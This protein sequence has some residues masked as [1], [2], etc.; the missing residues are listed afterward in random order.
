MAKKDV[1]GTMQVLTA[2]GALIALLEAIG[3]FANFKFEISIGGVGHGLGYGIIDAILLLIMAIITLLSAL[4]PNDTVSFNAGVL[5]IFGILII[6]F[7]S[8]LGG[9]LVIIAGIVG[10]LS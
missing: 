2:I 6:I 1:E 5:L 9:L 3:Y 8:V 7:G 10:I 4:E